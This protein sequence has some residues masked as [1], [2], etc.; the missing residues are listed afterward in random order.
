MLKTIIC[1][2]SAFLTI[3]YIML[4]RNKKIVFSDSRILVVGGTSGL[5]LSLARQLNNLDAK[6]TVASRTA[7]DL[8]PGIEHISIDIL[9]PETF[10]NLPTDYDY[11]FCCSGSSKP[12]FFNDLDQSDFCTQMELN[13]LGPVN[14]LHYF[15]RCNKKPFNYIFVSSTAAFFTFPG[16]SAY[17]P[18]KCALKS[19]FDSA[20]LELQKREVNLYIYYPTSMN[21]PGF[22]IENRGKPEYTKNIEGIR[23]LDPDDA[24]Q[25]LLTG[26]AGSRE[27]YS[28]FITQTFAHD[29]RIK[30]F[31]DIFYALTAFFICPVASV[32]IKYKFQRCE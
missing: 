26:M 23:G 25:R 6:V 17:S 11:I 15:L 14:M 18:S 28:D 4:K 7:K 31:G 32:Y 13:Y 10:Q 8:I 20:Y 24:A 29:A 5:G 16:Y 30:S 22:E 9:N 27:I 1:A 12:G 21:T 2:L 3:I 19:F